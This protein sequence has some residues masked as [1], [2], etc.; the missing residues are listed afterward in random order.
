MAA[1]PAFSEQLETWRRAKGPKTVAGLAQLT[2]DKSFACLFLVLMA[3]PALPLPTGGVTHIF[4]IITL[5]LALELIA[6]RRTI[7]LPRSWLQRP[8]GNNLRNK[9]LPRLIPMIRWLEKYSRRRGAELFEQQAWRRGL[10]LVVFGLTLS[11]LLAPPFSALDTLP[12]LAVVIV[13]LGMILNEVALVPIGLLIGGLGIA[14][15]VALGQAII[16]LLRHL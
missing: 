8:L 7:W 14:A 11:A 15:E 5:L 13:S 4:E 9:G 3:V 2:A 1:E 12:A 6:G 16:S 10:G